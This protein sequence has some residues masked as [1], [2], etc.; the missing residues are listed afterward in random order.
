MK[1]IGFLFAFGFLLISQAWDQ[2]NERELAYADWQV[3][4]P[5]SVVTEDY[6][7]DSI[8]HF[9]SLLALSDPKQVY[10]GVYEVSVANLAWGRVTERSSVR[11]AVG[12]VGD[13]KWADV[14]SDGA[15]ELLL[16]LDSSGRGFYNNLYVV[17]KTGPA[18]SYQDIFIWNAARIG[19]S[20]TPLRES[21]MGS[22]SI[23]DQGCQV[24]VSDIDGDGLLELFAPILLGPYRGSSPSPLWTGIFKWESGRYSEA[25]LQFQSFYSGVLL[26]HVEQRIA[27]LS[28]GKAEVQQGLDQRLDLEWVI[29]DRILRLFGSDPRAGLER[30]V[31]WARSPD[32]VAR[33]NALVELGEIPGEEARR[34]LQ[35][36][37]RDKDVRIAGEAQRLLRKRS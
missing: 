37:S 20:L 25:D 26:S 23:C 34:V 6:T 10:Q 31:G 9:L 14:D 30:A 15:Y 24:I 22:L 13:Y 2:T 1:M 3:D 4:G 21:H 36:L 28:E 16:V 7:K 18:F 32:P 35:E 33:Q 8:A 17:K 5:R 12:E 19:E 27:E 29:K 11:G